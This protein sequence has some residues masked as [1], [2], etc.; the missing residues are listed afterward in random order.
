MNEAMFWDRIAADE[1]HRMIEGGVADANNKL[2]P[3]GRRPLHAASLWG[4]A[5]VVPVLIRAGADVNARDKEGRT[6]L[7]EAAVEGHTGIMKEL[8][9]AGAD[10]ALRNRS[11]E[12]A[13]D[14]AA[15]FNQLAAV[16]LLDNWQVQRRG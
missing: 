3:G 10:P 15:A 7:M 11:G 13:R 4:S 16:E 14:C 9:E 5:P 6:A 2:S 8:L 1:C 12:T